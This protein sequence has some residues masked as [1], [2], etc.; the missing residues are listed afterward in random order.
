[1]FLLIRISNIKHLH[2]TKQLRKCTFG[3]L[4][5]NYFIELYNLLFLQICLI[6]Y[7]DVEKVLVNT[8][9]S[10]VAYFVRF[11]TLAWLKNSTML[12]ILIS[13]INCCFKKGT[14]GF[15]RNEDQFLRLRNV[16]AKLKVLN[17]LAD[18]SNKVHTQFCSPCEVESVLS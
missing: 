6:I 11:W 17:G 3:N 15:Y 4:L 7:T 5:T 16:E 1:M 9:I 12:I 10:G 2:G 8:V 13:F 14:R 18:C